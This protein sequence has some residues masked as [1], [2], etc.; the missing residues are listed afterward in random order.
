MKSKLVLASS[1]AVCLIVAAGI[2]L[3]I[4]GTALSASVW[5]EDSTN[6]PRNEYSVGETMYINW[7]E[8]PVGSTVDITVTDSAHNPLQTW[9]NQDPTKKLTLSYT[10]PAPGYYFIETAGAQPFLIAVATI[11]VIPESVL[12][13]LL[14][15]AVGFAAFGIVRMKRTK[16]K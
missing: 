7:N 16:N 4:A 11:F 8:N 2:S 5:A 6:T 10:F 13:T 3:A 9:L 14:A 12:G 15:V 1:L